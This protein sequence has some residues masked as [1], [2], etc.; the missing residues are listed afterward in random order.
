MAS[1]SQDISYSSLARYAKTLS[2]PMEEIASATNNFAIENLI[3]QDTYSKVFKGKLLHHGEP[4]NVV[5]HECLQVNGAI[6][7]MLMSKILEHKNIVSIFKVNDTPYE[8]FHVTKHQANES[9]DKHLSGSTLTWIQR[10]KICV[11]V[12]HAL[13]Y[14]HY[15]AEV[16]HSV[17]HGNIKSSKILLDHNW[18]PKLCG[19]GF[20]M[21]AKRNQL[22]LTSKYSGTLEYM[23]PAYEKTGGLTTKSDV[24]SFGVVLFEVLFGRKASD[25]IQG[26]DDNC[27]FSR[28]ARVHYEARTLDDMIDPDLLKQ[29]DLESLNVFSKTAY[30]CLK[31]LRAQRPSMDQIVK[32][33][34]RALELQQKHDKIHE[35]STAEIEAT[36][37]DHLKGKNL[38]HL[39][40]Q[41]NDI[42]F[43]T[44]KFSADQCIGSGGYGMVYK[45]KL[46][47]F[48]GNNSSAI[49][50]KNNGEFPKKNSTV[51]IKRIS[52]RLDGKGEQGFFAEI[53]MLSNC[54][55][56]N[57]VSLLGFCVE[58]PEMILVYELPPL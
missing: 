37:Y 43:A 24:F 40:I 42:E 5:V 15:G 23:D 19:F 58:G 25:H 4:I 2:I 34:E 7:E 38:D 3:S 46:D 26:N 41:W 12:A 30:W 8:A 10:L 22:H 55:H 53:E 20:A 1:S 51:A 45:A 32:T 31:E 13:H 57:I 54:K 36:N 9:L 14:I 33:L 50:K 52:S 47:H 39:K 27:N 21:R 6:N 56:R 29:M 28:L 17:I 35:H 48:D 11:G 49:E 44:N 18:E 16:N